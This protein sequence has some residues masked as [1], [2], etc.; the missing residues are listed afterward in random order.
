MRLMRLTLTVAVVAAVLVPTLTQAGQA[1][2]PQEAVAPAAADC[3]PVRV[4]GVRGFGVPAGDGGDR[5]TYESGGYGITEDIIKDIEDQLPPGSTRAALAHPSGDVFKYKEEVEGGRDK[6]RQYLDNSAWAC[7][8]TS[9]VLVGHS[10]GASVIGDVLD[11]ETEPQLSAAA[12]DALRAVVLLGDPKF[13]PDARWN[14]SGSPTTDS[15]GRGPW[16]FYFDE[17][18]KSRHA[19][20]FDE[21]QVESGPIIRSYCYPE[22]TTCQYGWPTSSSSGDGETIHNS[23]GDSGEFARTDAVAFVMSML[24]AASPPEPAPAPP[25]PAPVTT[26]PAIWVGS[27]TDGTWGCCAE[28]DKPDTSTTPGGVDAHHLLS[29]ADPKNDWSVDLPSRG[30]VTFVASTGDPSLDS[31][32]TA[33]VTQIDGATCISTGGG[34]GFVTVGIYFDGVL[35]GRATYA[36]LALNPALAVGTPVPLGSSLG[37]V[38]TEEQIASDERCWTGPHVH[39]EVRAETE[40]ACWAGPRFPAVGISRSQVLGYISGAPTTPGESYRCEGT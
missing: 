2:E 17:N 18:F 13:R 5:W 38:G 37:T 23:Y 32:L 21:Y 30:D 31:R 8:D 16:E 35:K 1:A 27:P 24:P 39:F 11:K 28:P 14:A 22:D 34:G 29:K 3:A 12:K 26:D 25:A 9:M 20:A 6:L 40:Y 33:A 10:Q 15:P 36:H 19:G 7:P 4:I